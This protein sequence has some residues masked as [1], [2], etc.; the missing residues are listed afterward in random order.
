MASGNA[1]R[2]L[3]AW[4]DLPATARLVLLVM[5]LT[6]RDNP[7]E[8]YDA[9]HYFG[10]AEFLQQKVW[11]RAD[12]STA[13]QL[14]KAITTLTRKG[15]IRRRVHGAP[16]R[17]AEYDLVL[18]RPEQGTETVPE[19]GT[20]TV[21]TGDRN[22]PDGGT[23]TVPPIGT[24]QKREK[25]EKEKPPQ[26]T[27]LSAPVDNS[28][29]DEIDAEMTTEQAHRILIDRHGARVHDV[30]AQHQQKC[31]DCPDAARHLLATPQLRVIEG[32]AA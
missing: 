3:D 4:P 23:E 29:Q 22:G 13:R 31:A 5:A 14:K 7:T 26:G 21:Q 20:E 2:A 24:T 28:A 1:Y 11:G 15:A 25:G 19:Q 18:T 16:G 9:A 30:I 27:N 6:A 32:G 12:E 17:R 8:E 10:G